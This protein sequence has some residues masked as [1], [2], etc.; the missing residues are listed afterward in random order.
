M[1]E[2]P[3][4]THELKDL[5]D[6]VPDTRELI[7]RR[8]SSWSAAHDAW[9]EARDDALDA[10]RGWRSA[11]AAE[12]YAAYRAAQDRADAAQDTLALGASQS[13]TSRTSV[14]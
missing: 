10:Y 14:S 4:S 13:Q 11:P 7:L 3:V 2:R 12:T 5:L 6:Q 1:P 8:A 9:S